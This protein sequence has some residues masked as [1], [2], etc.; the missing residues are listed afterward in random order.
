MHLFRGLISF[1]PT[2]IDSSVSQLHHLANVG[3]KK[4]TRRSSAGKKQIRIT[5]CPHEE[6]RHFWSELTAGAVVRAKWA[7]DIWHSPTSWQL[8][9][10]LFPL[11]THISLPSLAERKWGPFESTELNTRLQHLR[12][13]K[14][15]L[16]A[17]RRAAGH[18]G[19]VYPFQSA[20]NKQLT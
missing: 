13:L 2:Y 16:Q 12:T 11:H 7:V 17:L 8:Q 20:A 19:I 9:Q 5:Q 6:R 18:N 4:T 10:P 15:T 14:N 1:Q 3:W